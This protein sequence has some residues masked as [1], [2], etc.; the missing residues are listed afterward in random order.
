MEIENLLESESELVLLSDSE[1]IS[2]IFSSKSKVYTSDLLENIEG[3]CSLIT[4]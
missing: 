4:A 1:N 3:G 2:L